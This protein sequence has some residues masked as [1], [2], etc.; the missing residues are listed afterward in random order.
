MLVGPHGPNLLQDVAYIEETAHFNRERIPERVVHAKGGAAYGT[1]VVTNTEISKYTKASLFSKRGLSTPVAVRFSHVTGESGIA[2]T[3]RDVRGFAVKFYTDTGNWDLVGNNLPVFFIRDPI[4]FPSFIHS[5]KR[6][7]KTHL[8]DPNAFW[9]FITQLPE[10]LHTTTMLFTERGTPDGF[11]HMH[12][13]GVDTFKL[14]K[15]RMEAYYAKFHWVCNQG[16]R[17]LDQESAMQLAGRDPDYSIRDLQWAIENKNYPSWTLKFQVIPMKDAPKAGFNI[18]DAT[19]TW[20]FAKYPLH[21]VGKMTLKRNPE[22]YFTEVEQLAFSPANMIPGIEPSLDKMLIGRIFSYSDAQRYRLGGNFADLPVNKPHCPVMTPTYNDGEH[23]TT[24]MSS[25]VPNY[26]PS[27]KFKSLRSPHE[28]YLE[29][30][31]VVSGVVGRYDL[32]DDDNYSQVRIL[33]NKVLSDKN[34]LKLVNNIAEHLSG[35]SQDHIVGLVLKHYSQVDKM[36]AEDLAAALKKRT[37]KSYAI[38]DNK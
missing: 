19:K 1:F 33:I 18:F 24:N 34:R 27:G 36:F 8:R 32:S 20:P 23:F 31:Y 3:A 10:S 2:D 6:N 7:P 4:N 28:K 9:D 26:V 5:Q 17:N 22:N 25:S 29:H 14:V 35:V 13:Y 30:E 38:L 11:R 12:G 21:E 37:S 15:T 16:I